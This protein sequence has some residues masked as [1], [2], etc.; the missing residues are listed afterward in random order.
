MADKIFPTD[1]SL[2]TTAW[3]DLM[4][5]NDTSNPWVWFVEHTALAI[6]QTV[7]DDTST[8]TSKVWSANKVISYGASGTETLT[9]KTINVDNNAIINIEIDNLKAWVIDTDLTTVS[10][11]D[12]TIASAKATKTYTD[13]KVSKTGDETITGI[14][15]FSSFPI[16]PSSPP[17]TNYQI[18][19][20]KYVDDSV[21]NY[22]NTQTTRDL[23]TATGTQTVAHGLWYTPKIV[24][25][26][27]IMTLW[28]VWWIELW[29]DWSYN[30]TN[31]V[32][33]YKNQTWA[34]NYGVW[35]SSTK[36]IYIDQNGATQT[37]TITVDST[38]INISWTKTWS[39]TGTAFLTLIAH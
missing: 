24:D 2:V 21:S 6:A 10:A 25:I 19:N 27:T 32:C 18:A 38:N 15:T 3:D 4:V 31:N 17:T 5:W 11:S 20:K 39:P 8:W 12:D 14:K 23:T 28:V 16:T 26:F 1:T 9:N 7:I 36:C 29:S 30:G 33:V 13:T 37:A 35:W 22:F 34:S